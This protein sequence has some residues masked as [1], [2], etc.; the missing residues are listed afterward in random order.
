PRGPPSITDQPTVDF[1]LSERACIVTG[2]SR[3]IGR[4]TALRL[5]EEGASLLLVGR[6]EA[7]LAKAAGSCASAGGRGETL[8]LDVTEP[9]AGE[10]HLEVCR[11]RF[12]RVDVLVNNAGTSV[13]HPYE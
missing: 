2:A 3:G 11:E 5:A 12:G 4:A 10:R 7:A 13:I 1:G 9:D 6:D 8:A